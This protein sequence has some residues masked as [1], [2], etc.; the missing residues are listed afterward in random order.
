MKKLRKSDIIFVISVLL[1]FSVLF[2]IYYN[3]NVYCSINRRKLGE[4]LT[5]QVVEYLEN[6]DKD[7]LAELFSDEAKYSIEFKSN[8]D[9]LFNVLSG[10]D[11]SWSI[12]N[13]FDGYVKSHKMS[14]AECSFITETSLQTANSDGIC[15]IINQ[16]VSD[17]KRNGRKIGISKIILHINDE[18]IEIGTQNNE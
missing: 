3:S 4:K 16:A 6:G 2:A 7:S 10:E 12:I 13:D 9:E 15:T 5:K 8:L 18:W 14:I 11:I 1:A 17:G